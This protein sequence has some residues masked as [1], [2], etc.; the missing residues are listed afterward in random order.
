MMPR[1]DM[2]VDI[3]DNNVGFGGHFA[4]LNN[5]SVGFYPLDDGEGT[6]EHM[7]IAIIVPDAI[8]DPEAL[9]GKQ[10]TVHIQLNTFNEPAAIRELD[11]VVAPEIQGF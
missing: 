6:L 2:W 11:F 9:T 3:E 5:Y 4:R 10:G 7:Y 1:V 8:A